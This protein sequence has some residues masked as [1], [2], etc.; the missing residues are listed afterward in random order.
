MMLVKEDRHRS[1]ILLVPINVTFWKDQTLGTG[2]KSEV[3]RVW[4][5]NFHLEWWKCSGSWCGG[6]Y[7][8]A[9]IF[10]KSYN[11]T[12]KKGEFY[13]IIHYNVISVTLKNDWEHQLFKENEWTS[14]IL[15]RAISLVKPEARL[16]KWHTFIQWGRE[17]GTLP[18]MSRAPL[19]STAS[20]KFNG[21]M[22]SPPACNSKVRKFGGGTKEWDVGS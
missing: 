11:C 14:G 6:S 4:R 1:Y 15:Q 5:R 12:L 7:M 9:C 17:R 21:H 18:T 8:I 3:T 13:Y 16:R 10:Q 2:S 20:I 19:L 22:P